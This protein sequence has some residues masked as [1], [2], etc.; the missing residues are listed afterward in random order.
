MT[1]LQ[2]Y[3]WP[4]NIRE[5]RNIIEYAAII[6]PVDELKVRLPESGS[7]RL[8]HRTT[9]R[10]VEI[11]HIEDILR[12]TAWRIKGDGGAAQILGMNP[13]TLYS[14]MKKLGISSQREKDGMSS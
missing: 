14:R 3:S 4:G 12:Q 13:A 5:L 2:S 11:S 8:S 6:S 9:L 10:E 7:D 1:S